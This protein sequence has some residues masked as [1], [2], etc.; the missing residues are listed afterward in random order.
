MNVNQTANGDC[1]VLHWYI[2]D[3]EDTQNH[4]AYDWS[5]LGTKS[6]STLIKNNIFNGAQTETHYFWNA[7]YELD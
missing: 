3:D 2:Q 1:N 6:D 5:N 7:C 4:D